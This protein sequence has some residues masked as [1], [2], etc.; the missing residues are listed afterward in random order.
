LR[1]SVFSVANSYLHETN[2]VTID[3]S[4]VQRDT[5]EITSYDMFV[6]AV[7]GAVSNNTNIKSYEASHVRT[8]I[9]NAEELSPTFHNVPSPDVVNDQLANTPNTFLRLSNEPRGVLCALNTQGWCRV[10]DRT[11]MRL[12]SAT[13]TSTLIATVSNR[14]LP[15]NPTSI[16]LILYAQQ[17]QDSPLT[18]INHACNVAFRMLGNPTVATI[19]FE[20]PLDAMRVAVTPTDYV[21]MNNVGATLNID[22]EAFVEGTPQFQNIPNKYTIVSVLENLEKQSITIKAIPQFL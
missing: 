1:N 14:P 5:K 22:T 11:F 13:D 4:D 9:G 21:D 17:V 8:D 2:P 18:T 12:S 20:I 7:K 15:V 19:K 6:N 3:N 16:D 10:H